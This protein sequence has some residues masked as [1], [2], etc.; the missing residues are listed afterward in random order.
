MP[1][2]AKP[3]RVST[4]EPLERRQTLVRRGREVADPSAGR[5][6]DGIDD[7]GASAANS[8]FADALAPERVAVGI[9]LVDEHDVHVADVGIDRDAVVRE[10]LGDEG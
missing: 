9:V 3:K 6:V 4:V 1:T 8:Q 7:R 2:V 5:V 10:I